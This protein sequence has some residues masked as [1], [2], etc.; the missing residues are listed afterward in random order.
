M[1]EQARSLTGWTNSWSRGRGDY[2]FRFDAK[3]HDAGRKT[4]FRRSGDFDWKDA[5]RLCVTERLHAGVG[6]SAR[7]RF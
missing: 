7:V 5:C 6:L 3:G 1:R 2:N 4:V